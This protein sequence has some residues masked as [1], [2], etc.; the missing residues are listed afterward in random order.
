MVGRLAID[1]GTSNTVV[2][3]WDEIQQTG[4]PLHVRDFGRYYQQ[5]NTRISVIPSVIHLTNDNR[6]WIGNQVLQQ[7][8]YNSRQTFRWMKRYISNR[9]PHKLRVAGRELSHFDA[10]REF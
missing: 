3:H 8:L 10:G 6:S 7:N 4:V 5:E 1:F 9:S 2:A